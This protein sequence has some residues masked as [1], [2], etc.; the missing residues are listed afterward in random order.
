[1]LGI[2]DDRAAIGEPNHAVNAEAVLSLVAKTPII[3]A[4]YHRIR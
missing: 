3:V 4:Y 1:M 2:F